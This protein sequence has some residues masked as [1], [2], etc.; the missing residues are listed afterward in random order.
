MNLSVER[1]DG[2]LYCLVEGRVDG[3][4]A[5]DF[6]AGVID[7][8]TDDD[9]VLVLD[10]SQVSYIS[11]AGLQSFLLI[12]RSMGQRSVGFGICELSDGVRK[13]FEIAGFS[14]VLALFSNREEALVALGRASV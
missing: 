13:V 7:H 8:V 12:A 6:R 4:N 14:G 2:V 5:P 11:S 3:D 1:E 9:R 10:L